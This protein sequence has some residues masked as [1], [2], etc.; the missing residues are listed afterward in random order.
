MEKFKIWK[1]K[2]TIVAGKSETVTT[3]LVHTPLQIQTISEEI[4]AALN[5]YCKPTSE[6]TDI[7]TSIIEHEFEFTNGSEL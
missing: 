7:H 6:I 4:K 1:I 5:S 2:I 3:K